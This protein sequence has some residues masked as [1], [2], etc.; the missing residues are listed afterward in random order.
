MPFTFSPETGRYRDTTS[1]HLVSEATVRR[2]VD[3]VADAASDRLADLSARLLRGEL[4]LSEFQ[5]E[6]MRVV[7]TA[8]VATGIVAHG[9]TA[10][11]TPARWG[12]LGSRIKAEYGYLRSFAEQIA[13]G[14]QVLDGRLAARARLYGQASRATFSA[15][16][17]RDQPNRG[18]VSERNILNSRES[19]DQCRALS[20][21]GWV[22]IGSLPIPGG[23]ECVTNC[24]CRLAYSMEAAAAA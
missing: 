5:L 4:K 11:M 1:G 23:R 16:V 15:A 6:A 8:H 12:F 18:Y 20:A 7:K 21:L 2:A 3:A 13:D 22:P 14:T 19:C 10:Q 24:H 9:G 17:A